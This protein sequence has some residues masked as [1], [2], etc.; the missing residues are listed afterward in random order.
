[1][2]TAQRF[3]GYS[4]RMAGSTALQLPPPDPA[5]VRDCV[6]AQFDP[7]QIVSPDRD[8]LHDIDETI[9]REVGLLLLPDAEREA[10]IRTVRDAVLGLGF[11]EKYRRMGDVLEIAL[12]SDG[13]MWLV[14]KGI[15]GWCE[16]KDFA[17]P[18]AEVGR[19]LSVVLGQL[20]R[21]VSFASPI[22]SARLSTGERL[23]VIAWP[24]AVPHG[25]AVG[26]QAY[27]SFD[28]RFFEPTPVPPPQLLQWGALSEE[29]MDFLARLVREH[30]SILVCGKTGSGKTTLLS[31]L[32]HFIPAGDR[33]VSIEDVQELKLAAA[34]WQPLETRPA[35]ISGEYEITQEMLV[36]ASL[37]MFPDWVIVGEVRHPAVA[38]ALL[39][40]QASGHA[41]LSTFHAHSPREAVYRLLQLLLRTGD[42]P[43]AGPAKMALALG[44]DAV[45]Q[46]R[47]DRAMNM[48]RVVRIDQVEPRLQSGELRT[49]TL[50]RYDAAATLAASTVEKR[51]DESGR[52]VPVTTHDRP[53]WICDHKFTRDAAGR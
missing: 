30:R 38:V 22:E 23:H 18:A 19:V 14:R 53:V 51:W 25:L 9:T 1:M 34:N 12:N 48:R 44:L 50:Y 29:M 13:R 15:P 47:F 32:S 43:N 27:P 35:S 40:A 5:D 39:D 8:T 42:F 16:D 46:V 28:L 17:V 7:A 4:K 24:V 10:L 36:A 26:Q 31:A 2:T 37:R 33:V 20:N 49:T 52:E 41:G 3:T 6:V 21:Q 45:V 11:L